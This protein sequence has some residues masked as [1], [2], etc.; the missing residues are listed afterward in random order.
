MEKLLFE[1]SKRGKRAVSL[2]KC[3]VEEVNPEEVIPEEYLR[4]DID[5]PEVSQLEVVRHFPRLSQLNYSVDTN[6]YPLGSCTM[7]T[8]RG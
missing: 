2:P 8:T 1:L 7:N 3:D 6:F 5:L 4:K